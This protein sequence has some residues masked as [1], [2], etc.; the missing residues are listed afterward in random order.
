[1]SRMT[2]FVTAAA[3]V[4]LAGG[5]V[6]AIFA[7]CGEQD[8]A[9]LQRTIE[10]IK[11][12]AYTE[13]EQQRTAM[14]E[15]FPDRYQIDIKQP[16]SHERAE[17]FFDVA[18]NPDDNDHYQY[19]IARKHLNSFSPLA[20]TYVTGLADRKIVAAAAC[21]SMTKTF[22]YFEELIKSFSKLGPGQSW[23]PI[24]TAV[25]DMNCRFPTQ[26]APAPATPPH[27]TVAVYDRILGTSSIG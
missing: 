15:E 25:E 26:C 3:N 12:A 11:S 16:L 21:V 23:Q 6:V 27:K 2:E 8:T 4:V 18:A 10:F 17:H 22:I 1:M 9:R 5:V 14:L 7:Y 19:N 20:F 13:D 24:K